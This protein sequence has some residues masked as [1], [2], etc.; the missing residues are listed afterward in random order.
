MKYLNK[1]RA[2]IV[3]TLLLVICTPLRLSVIL[4]ASFTYILCGSVM[5]LITGNSKFISKN[6]FLDFLGS[7]FNTYSLND[8]FF[9]PLVQVNYTI[10][11][12]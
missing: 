12:N 4:F 5:V 3:L 7:F 6:E 1:L 8:F 11:V 9:F 2:L 10:L